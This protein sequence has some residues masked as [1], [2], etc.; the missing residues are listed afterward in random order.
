MADGV[1]PV[2]TIRLHQA[3]H[4]YVDGHCQLALSASLRPR[5]Q[6]RLLAL[7]DISGPSAC[8]EDD[9][10]LTGYPLQE[11]AFFALG[12]T[13]P[14]PE[15]PRPGCVWTHTL[16]ISFTDLAA[17]NTLTGLLGMFRRPLGVHAAPGYAKPTILSTNAPVCFTSFTEDWAR[18]IIGGLYGKPRRRIVATG[19]G[20]QV[21]VVVLALWSQQWPRLRRSFSFCTLATRDRSD[22]NG[23]FDLQVLPDS[24]RSIRTRFTDALDVDSAALGAARWVDDAIDDLVQPNGAG[25]RDLF[26]RLGADIAVG[27]E[28]FRPLCLLHRALRA[29]HSR[30]ETVTEAVEVLHHEFGTDPSRAARTTVAT[31]AFGQAEK[32]DEPSFRFLWTNLGLLDPETLLTGALRLG[33][34]AWRRDPSL[35][36]PLLTEESTRGVVDRTLTDLDLAELVTGLAQAPALRAAALIRRPEVLAQPAFWTN[37]DSVGP[38]FQAAK[39]WRVEA[40]LSALMLA[41]RHDLAADAV[42]EFGCAATLRALKAVWERSPNEV[43]AWLQPSTGDVGAVAEFLVAESTIPRL[44]MYRLA[45]DLAPESVPNDYGEDPWLIAQ[46]HSV[47]EIDGTESTY[48]NAYLLSRA[49]TQ[50]TRCAGELAH[51]SFESTH[52]ALA[53]NRLAYSD[54]RLLE[55]RLPWSITWWEWDRCFR[56]RA[57]IVALFVDRDLA[58]RLFAELC[59][60]DELFALL[61]ERAARIKRGRGYL[62]RVRRFLRNA[63]NEQMAARS[64]IINRVIGCLTS[65]R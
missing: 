18:R 63:P 47:G 26:R 8:L 2:P 30:A 34:S 14:A 4:G 36:I 3:L 12:R 13:W 44:M 49:L 7:S 42:H 51:L 11:S 33:R 24:D 46:R 59:D 41:G 37:L 29:S 52:A 15:M 20:E 6:K 56:L 9:G 21:D 45:R 32:L 28:A 17:L 31:A 16:L 38:A 43:G 19:F 62:K 65:Y 64:S 5:D 22:Q 61:A 58:P 48:L 10:Y 50:R 40:T 25:L 35:L 53:S 1:I 60:S 54:W 39:G 27:R 55:T 57:G 23:N